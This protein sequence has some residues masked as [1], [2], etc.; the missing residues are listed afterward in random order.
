MGLTSI[1][2][3][4]KDNSKDGS[5]DGDS[6]VVNNVLYTNWP[7]TLNTEI[8][9]TETEQL[10]QSVGNIEAHTPYYRN[11]YPGQIFSF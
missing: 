7:Q 4:S 1:K 9:K 8:E 5:K 3:Q 6:S 10:Q 2:D 11:P